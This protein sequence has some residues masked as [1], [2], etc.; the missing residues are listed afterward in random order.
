MRAIG[1][2]YGLVWTPEGSNL[3]QITTKIRKGSGKIFVDG[4]I[5]HQFLANMETAYYLFQDNHDFNLEKHNITFDVPGPVDGYSVGLPLFVAMHSALT[6]QPVN[7]NVAFT[8]ALSEAGC[9]LAVP[10]IIE[11]MVAC[12]RANLETIVMPMD[13]MPELPEYSRTAPWGHLAICP[14]VRALEAL[15]ISLPPEVTKAKLKK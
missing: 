1:Q 13:N 8:G 5:D 7:Q 9:V 4:D 10:G 3:V 2:A 11:K 12:R 6:K 15:V 14:I